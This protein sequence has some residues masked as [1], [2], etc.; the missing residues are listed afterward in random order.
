MTS[1]CPH[2][3]RVETAVVVPSFVQSFLAFP[4][5]VGW[6]AQNVCLEQ[7]VESVIRMQAVSEYFACQ[8]SSQNITLSVPGLFLNSSK[9]NMAQLIWDCPLFQ[10]SSAVLCP[11]CET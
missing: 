2:Y 9:S 11:V 5:F 7:F 10:I 4:L 6:L 3:F 8:W 1:P